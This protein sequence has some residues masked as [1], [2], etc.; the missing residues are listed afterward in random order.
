MKIARLLF[1]LFSGFTLLSTAGTTLYTQSIDPV[2]QKCISRLR[3]FDGFEYDASFKMKFFDNTDTT[4][5]YTRHC[6]V[7]KKQEDTILKYH[8]I[9]SNG[10]TDVGYTGE[11]FFM[12]NKKES[13]LKKEKSQVLGRNFIR[14]NIGTNF[15]PSYLYS[16]DPVSSWIKAAIDI[17]RLADSSSSGKKYYVI[18][19]SFKADEEI[20]RSERYLYIDKKTFLP[21]SMKIYAE[22]KGIQ[23]E[24]QELVI[25]NLVGL[26]NKEAAIHYNFT[27]G[28]EPEPFNAAGKKTEMPALEVG[29]TMPDFVGKYLNNKPFQPGD[30]SEKKLVL[31]D[32]WYLACPPCLKAIPALAVIQNDFS[33]KGLQVIG[34]NSTDTSEKKIAE[35]KKFIP[36]LQMNYPV[37][38]IGKETEKAF[39]VTVWPTF[40]LIENG[41]V[42]Y[43]G[44]GYDENEFKNLRT[45][46]EQ[47]LSGSK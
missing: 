25:K 11:D 12:S 1:S 19:F 32:F 43:T 9:V 27:P 20:T 15:V 21:V 45:I 6:R 34:L 44:K 36:A 26:K 31:L 28:L 23:Q 17:S 38:L 16:L 10:S 29:T 39:R 4:D 37:I 7:L 42:I 18:K 46:I 33:T 41:K 22:Y 2:L 14:N 3:E 13:W 40:Y 8:A 30:L 47:R 5:F 35:I 24:Y